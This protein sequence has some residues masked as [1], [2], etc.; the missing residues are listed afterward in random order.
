MTCPE[1]LGEAAGQR[2]HGKLVAHMDE[3]TGPSAAS[4]PLWVHVPLIPIMGIGLK[5]QTQSSDIGAECVI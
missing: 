4:C 5:M 3:R 1:V 2:A